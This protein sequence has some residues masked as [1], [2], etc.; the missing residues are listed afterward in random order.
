MPPGSGP[1]RPYSTSPGRLSPPL[2]TLHHHRHML[3][4]SSVHASLLLPLLRLHPRLMALLLAVAPH[5][6][7]GKIRTRVTTLRRKSRSVIGG[8]A[9]RRKP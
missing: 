3:R 7:L 4:L 6:N 1:P 2:Q 5:L 9:A 8:S